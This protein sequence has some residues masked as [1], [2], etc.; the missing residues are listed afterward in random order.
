M[1]FTLSPNFAIKPSFSEFKFE[2]LGHLGIRHHCPRHGI[3]YLNSSFVDDYLWQ[4]LHNEVDL[5]YMTWPRQWS[6]W[7]PRPSFDL[8]SRVKESTKWRSTTND[9]DDLKAFGLQFFWIQIV[10]LLIEEAR[11]APCGSSSRIASRLRPLIAARM[12]MSAASRHTLVMSAPARTCE[13]TAITWRACSEG[14]TKGNNGS[15]M[16]GDRK[17]AWRNGS[18]TGRIFA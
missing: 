17:I 13:E 9:N 10:A 11:C 7:S 6:K 12:L 16:R 14:G 18:Y 3:S 4:F 8:L 15:G 5:W 1:H 2:S